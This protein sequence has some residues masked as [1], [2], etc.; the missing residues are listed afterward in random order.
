MI[1]VWAKL[2]DRPIKCSLD[3][4]MWFVGVFWW[5]VFAY[6]ILNHPFVESLFIFKRVELFF[7]KWEC[8][9]LE[10]VTSSDR[11]WT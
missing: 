1:H 6:A 5:C 11:A 2:C 3:T 4:N 9:V 8:S 10:C 7:A